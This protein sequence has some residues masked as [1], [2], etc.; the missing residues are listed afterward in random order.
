MCE[1]FRLKKTGLIMMVQDFWSRKGHP[2]PTK[3]LPGPLGLKEKASLPGWLGHFMGYAGWMG[4]ASGAEALAH[5]V[6]VWLT[7]FGPLRVALR[8]SVL[9]SLSESDNGKKITAALPI[10]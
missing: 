2:L 6:R 4:L 10:S 7:L 9:Y 3:S 5:G 8:S 1:P